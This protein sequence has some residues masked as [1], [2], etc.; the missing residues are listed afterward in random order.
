MTEKPFAAK[1]KNGANGKENEVL[2]VKKTNGFSKA[3]S[4]RQAR[5]FPFF[6]D[7]I[8][9]IGQDAYGDF[10]RQKARKKREKK[11]Y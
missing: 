6:D 8:F 5:F 2:S 10:R 3:V 4:K 1:G 9:K 7:D 11:P